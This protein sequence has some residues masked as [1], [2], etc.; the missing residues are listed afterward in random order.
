[1]ARPSGAPR[2]RG[3]IG[4][5]DLCM[6]TLIRNAGLRASEVLHLHVHGIGWTSGHLLVREGNGK[7]DRILW[8]NDADLELLHSWPARRLVATASS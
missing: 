7:G 1:M 3:H 6:L 5:R 4:H 8:L 2:L